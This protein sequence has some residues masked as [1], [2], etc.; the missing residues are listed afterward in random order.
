[1]AAV[2]RVDTKYYQAAPPHSLGERLVVAARNRMFADFMHLCAPAPDDAVLDVGVSDV[3]NDGANMLEQKY[4]WQHRITAAG[5]GV[6]NEFRAAFPAA[7]YVQIEAGR[8]LPFA[9]KTFRIATANAVLE[10]VGSRNAQIAFIS[11]LLRVAD[12]IFVT[13]PHRYFPVEH[14]TALPLLHY[15]DWSFA[16][17]C[18][19][20]GR[21]EWA[22]PRNLILMTRRRLSDLLPSGLPH[23]IGY[24]GLQLG[25]LSSNLYLWARA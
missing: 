12:T 15:W 9:D 20:S 13:V 19:L 3:V 14:H 2:E 22:S 11:E 18:N 17:A 8:P 7:A 21:Q 4:P 16:L 6:A 23:A 5:L 24:S 25:P 1:M 10:H